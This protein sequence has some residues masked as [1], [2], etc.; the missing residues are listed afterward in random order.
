MSSSQLISYFS[1]GLK[2][3]TR[4]LGVGDDFD[5]PVNYDFGKIS[6]RIPP[7]QGTTR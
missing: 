3:P 6:Q 1:E 2:P 5:Q 7:V 4:D